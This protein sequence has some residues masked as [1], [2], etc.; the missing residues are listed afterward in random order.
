MA[1]SESFK[2]LWHMSKNIYRRSPSEVLL[3]KG[4]LKISSKFMEHPCR[5]MIWIKLFCNLNSAWVLSCTFAAYFQSM[6][7]SGLLWTAV[8]STKAPVESHICPMKKLFW[9]SEVPKFL[10]SEVTDLQ[11]TFLLK[12]ESSTGAFCDFFKGAPN[13]KF[14]QKWDNQI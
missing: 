14:G 3:G 8:N 5:S 10:I 1:A 6:F 4:V 13:G 9:K 7:L 12:G 2:D 11:L